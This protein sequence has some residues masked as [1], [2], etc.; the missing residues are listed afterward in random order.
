MELVE[1][2]S[3]VPRVPLAQINSLGR[4][5]TFIVSINSKVCNCLVVI[6]VDL[7]EPILSRFDILCVVKDTVDP[8]QVT[9]SCWCSDFNRFWSICRVLG[10]RYC[11]GKVTAAFWRDCEF[12]RV[13]VG[14][15]IRWIAVECDGRW[16]IL[17]TLSCC[18]TTIVII[19]LLL[20]KSKSKFFIHSGSALSSHASSQAH[21]VFKQT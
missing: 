7:T 20:S 8:V 15:A 14:V 16:L 3:E 19:L 18:F 6:Q 9:H 12:K 1:R 10:S 11:R 21:H 4:P 17:K 2:F 5:V 13:D